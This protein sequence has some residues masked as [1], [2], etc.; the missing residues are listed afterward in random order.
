[1]SRKDTT[2]A[3]GDIRR[4][5]RLA[6][7]ERGLTL[8]EWSRSHGYK[9][10]TVLEVLRRHEAKPDRV[11]HGKIAIQIYHDLED[12]LGIVLLKRAA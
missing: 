2:P 3:G 10:N 5:L 9:S 4:R 1:M 12:D 7:F 11:T 6:L 8:V